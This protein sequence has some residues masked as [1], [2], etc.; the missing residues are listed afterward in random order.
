MEKIQHK[1]FQRGL[2]PKYDVP[3]EIVKCIGNVTYKLKLPERLK[4]HPTFHVSFLKPYHHD[5]NL[6]RVQAKRNPPMIRVEFGKEIAS[7]LQNRKMGNWKNKG[8]EYLIH[9]KGTPINEASC[10]KGATLWQ[11]EDLINEYARLKS[12][13]T[14]TTS[15]GEGLLAPRLD[16]PSSMR[17]EGVALALCVNHGRRSRQIKKQVLA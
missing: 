11:F 16:D 17:H 6:D 9:W 4:F 12:T 15:S 13:R 1:Q 7:I 5:P 14:T 10:E 3:F 8:T 2:I